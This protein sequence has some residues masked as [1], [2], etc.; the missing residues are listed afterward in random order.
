MQSLTI[1]KA[2]GSFLM[3]LSFKNVSK[4][5]NRYE[6][7]SPTIV[8]KGCKGLTYKAGTNVTYN[9]TLRVY[10]QQEFFMRADPSSEG[11]I[12]RLLSS[13]GMKT[14]CCYSTC[15]VTTLLTNSWHLPQM[16]IDI[17]PKCRDEML[18]S[19]QTLI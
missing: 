15:M 3:C 17:F 13:I 6:P 2:V 12:F 18:L 8:Q 11:E 19:T 5:L 16:S 10:N 9:P 1:C 4:T 14:Q 7:L